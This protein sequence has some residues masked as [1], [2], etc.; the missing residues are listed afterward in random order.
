MTLNQIIVL[1]IITVFLA[2]F[3]ALAYRRL[4]HPTK[5]QQE[6]NQRRERAFRR[7]YLDTTIATVVNNLVIVWYPNAS[8]AL[9][10]SHEE[11]ESRLRE[12]YTANP[13]ADPQ[14]IGDS[15]HI[16]IKAIERG[17]KSSNHPTVIGE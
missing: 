9:I 5:E 11:V 12:I 13:H 17:T 7:L 14:L 10:P 8:N 4:F 6:L 2:L 16:K 1:T 15:L 3:L